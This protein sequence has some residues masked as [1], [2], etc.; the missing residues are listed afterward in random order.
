MR[1]LSEGRISVINEDGERTTAVRDDNVRQAGLGIGYR[2]R[3]RFRI[4][5]EGS[6]TTRRSHF[7]DLGIQGL[8]IGASL[9]YIP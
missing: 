1:L 8:L 2:I 9:N 3:S 5:L 6:Y 7:A 4:G